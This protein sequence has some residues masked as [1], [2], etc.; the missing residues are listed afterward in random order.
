M[1]QGEG[2]EVAEDG[3]WLLLKFIDAIR[4][5]LELPFIKTPRSGQQSKENF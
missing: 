1:A 5:Y 3:S 4:P 2:R